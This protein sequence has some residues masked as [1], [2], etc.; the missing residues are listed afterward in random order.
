MRYGAD[1]KN[2]GEE[3]KEQISDKPILSEESK[4]NR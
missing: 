4:E 2:L 3:S 1:L